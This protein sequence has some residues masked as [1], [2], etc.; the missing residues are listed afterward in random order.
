MTIHGELEAFWET[1]TEGV[2]WSMID[3][4]M[5]GYDGLW[6]LKDG[7]RL[8]VLAADDTMLWE[9]VIQLEYERN[10]QPYDEED[11]EYGQQAVHG[12]WVHGLQQDVDPQEWA[13]MF[14]L[15]H[16]ALLDLGPEQ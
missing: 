2:Y 11:T 3:P 5:P 8:C 1:G 16:R 12:Y 7:D 9:G 6:T 13:D 4:S 15:R 10:W 14:F